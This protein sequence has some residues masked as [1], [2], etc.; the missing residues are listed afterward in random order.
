LQP[1]VGD[2]HAGLLPAVF[3]GR[4][5]A[6]VRRLGLLGNGRQRVQAAGVGDDF[7]VFQ[8]GSPAGEA[9]VSGV[10]GLGSVPALPF[11]SGD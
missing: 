8:V 5:R 7:N 3:A 6:Q 9:L 1:V 10:S 11:A 4:P 2:Q